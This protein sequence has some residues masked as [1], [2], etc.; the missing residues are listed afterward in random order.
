MKK[1]LVFLFI[2]V[3]SV[4]AAQA[5]SCETKYNNGVFIQK[6]QLI[7]LDWFSKDR[8]QL[9]LGGVNK[10][11]YGNYYK[12][13]MYAVEGS[14]EYYLGGQYKELSGT[15]FV[16][17]WATRTG[18]SIY[19]HL[20][21]IVTFNVYLDDQL[22]YSR[23]GLDVRSK[24]EQLLFD[25]RGAEF[26]RLEFR[27]NSYIDSGMDHVLAMFANAELTPW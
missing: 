9:T 5:G 20:W 4:S 6:V 16:H 11:N 26:L 13:E 8:F 25:V 24:P 17:N 2:L 3:L 12:N 19:G 7:D 1:A 22:I 18:Y 10:D 15:L 23:T 21:D 27:N 14:I